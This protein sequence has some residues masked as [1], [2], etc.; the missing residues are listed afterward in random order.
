[1]TSGND[2][3]DDPARQGQEPNWWQGAPAQESPWQPGPQG[4]SGYG[5][6]QGDQTWQFGYAPP[7]PTAQFTGGQYGTG[8]GYPGQA[9]Q[10]APY[11]TGPYQA[12]GAPYGGPPAQPPGG[13]KRTGWVFAGI[14]VLVLAIVG[15]VVTVVLVNG[16]SDSSSAQSNTTPSLISA[17]TTTPSGTRTTTAPRTTAPRTS[18]PG[19]VIP[20]YQVVSM[21]ELGAA[22]DVPQDWTIDTTGISAFDSGL[23]RIPVVG[24]AQEGVG[25]CTNYTR[26]TAFLSQSAETD[27]A[28][29]AADIGVRMG[30]IGWPSTTGSTPG[31]AE[32]FESADG[33]LSGVF[34]EIKGSAPAPTSGCAS[35]YTI[36]TFA[37]PGEGGAFVLTIG[38]DTGVDKAVDRALA[39]QILASIRATA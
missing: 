22:Y 25:Y 2:R 32:P 21:P 10:G 20:G 39:Q 5:V 7:N 15:A 19:A 1:M 30:R 35:T 27:P 38:A 24:L 6:P 8:A 31:N 16:G 3:N 12:P 18:A 34:M 33:T 13:G 14:G 29:A 28:R 9:P 11:Q 17:L 23:D 36:Y 26:T 37:F 4:Q